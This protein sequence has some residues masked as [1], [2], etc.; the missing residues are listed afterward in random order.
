MQTWSYSGHPSLLLTIFTMDYAIAACRTLSVIT[1]KAHSN[2]FLL[3]K[4]RFPRLYHHRR[5][6]SIAQSHAHE[7]GCER[8]NFWNSATIG[9]QCL[10][11]Q[12]RCWQDFG[13]FWLSQNTNFS[14]S[15]ETPSSSWPVL[16]QINA[17]LLS[18]YEY[19]LTLSRHRADPRGL[20]TWVIYY[21]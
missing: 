9:S 11:V 6:T 1:F 21:L 14:S 17:R 4:T 3:S 15:Y 5:L 18:G 20:P 7:H 10:C 12:L 13:V 16:N 8:R 2:H 19:C